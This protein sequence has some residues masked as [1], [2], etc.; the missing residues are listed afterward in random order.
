MT[1]PYALIAMLAQAIALSSL[2]PVHGQDLAVDIKFPSDNQFLPKSWTLEPISAST[3]ALPKE[4]QEKAR[5][6]IAKG[7]S[8]Y[9]KELAKKYLN[10]VSIV[11]SLKFYG[12]GYGGTYMSNSK[13][14][15]LV[16]RPEFDPRGFEQR[17]HHEFSSILLK[18]NESDFEKKRW[19]TANAPG[20]EYRAG[21]VIEEQSGDRS[22]ATKVLAAEQ[23]KTG[24]SGS[25]LLT[26]DAALMEEGFLTAY[27]RVSVEQD[28]NETVAHLF[29]NPE[30]W[31][32]SV[33]YPR[34]DQKVDILI[35]FFR[36][37]DPEMDRIYFRN[38]TR[39]E[40]AT[41]P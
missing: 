37:L 3:V 40:L 27:N 25:T 11:K 19:L 26:L 20:F 13:R 1:K 2:V 9:P 22:E 29:T 7:L 32:L 12:V 28:V 17:L 30:L 34:I 36:T 16:Y 39:G 4:H 35:D 38:L 8:K 24:G 23:E 41:Y 6:I 10:D 18:M 14:V 5:K 33:K 31:N 21:G 15:L